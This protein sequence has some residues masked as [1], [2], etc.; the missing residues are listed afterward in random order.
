MLRV[1]ASP[2]FLFTKTFL[3][4]ALS[5]L[6]SSQIFLTVSVYLFLLMMPFLVTVQ[7]RL[8]RHML[9]SLAWLRARLQALMVCQWNFMLLSEICLLR[10]L[11]AFSMLLWRLVSCCRKQKDLRSKNI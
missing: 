7:S 8:M 9:L 4:P 3:R 1:F 2:R 11:L 5:I 6:G 10:V